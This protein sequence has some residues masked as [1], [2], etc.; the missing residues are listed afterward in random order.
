M[1]ITRRKLFQLSSLGTLAGIGSLTSGCDLGSM[2][3]VPSRETRY[4]TPND[5]FY[6]V[7]YMDSPYNF[8]RDLDQEQWQMI[9]KGQ[10]PTPWCSRGGT[11]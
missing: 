2:F 4:F 6:T 3:A 10:S 11:S 8:T 9:V 5:K 7:N 1:D